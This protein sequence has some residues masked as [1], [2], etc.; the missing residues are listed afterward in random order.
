MIQNR[1]RFFE[2]NRVPN[3]PEQRKLIKRIKRG[4][5]SGSGSMRVE[6]DMIG[7]Y[8]R[9]SE[10]HNFDG[11]NPEDVRVGNSAFND[12]CMVAA[13]QQV[14]SRTYPPLDDEPLFIELSDESQIVDVESYQ[15]VPKQLTP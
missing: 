1:A 7:D 15:Y 6:F 11:S 3:D 2:L 13:G 8:L 5:P 12:I 14:V 4:I 10:W 9:V